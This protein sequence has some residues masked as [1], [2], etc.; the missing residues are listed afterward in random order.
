[1]EGIETT[2]ELIETADRRL[3]LA[4]KMG[5]NRVVSADL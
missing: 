4:K 2:E 3:Y 5:R 1:M